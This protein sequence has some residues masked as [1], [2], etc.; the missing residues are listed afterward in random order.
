MPSRT[1]HQRLRAVVPTGLARAD[2]EA[3]L[4]GK[5]PTPDLFARSAQAMR[6]DI[7][8]IDDVRATAAYRL[9]CAQTL[10]Q[11]ALQAACLQAS[12]TTE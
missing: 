8:P 10:L 3:V 11:R 5:R 4:L 7:S 6:T 9:H 1:V 12:E 2:A